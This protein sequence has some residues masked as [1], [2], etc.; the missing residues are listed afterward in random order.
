M[1]AD[2]AGNITNVPLFV[3]PADGNFRLQSASPCIN[4]GNDV[5][6]YG[7]TDLDGNPRIVGGTVDIGAYEFQG[8]GSVISYAWLQEYGLP[9]DSSADFLDSDRDG[10]NNWQEW[11]CATC[12]TNPISVLRLI[13]A[14][15]SGSDVTVSWQS[16]AGV[17]YFLER[18]G[19]LSAPFTLAGT[20]V[21]GQAGTTTFADTN[22]SGT[23]PFFYRVR[24]RYP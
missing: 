24:V 5:R 15:P 18:S 7:T 8:A 14:I 1:P 23:G 6:V 10:L 19:E 4:S 13:S 17:T 20:N 16:A 12:P 21:V 9:T 2:G 11:I 22:A 3:S